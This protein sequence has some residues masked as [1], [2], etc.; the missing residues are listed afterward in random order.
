MLTIKK[1][2]N[3][4][5]NSSSKWFNLWANAKNKHRSMRCFGFWCVD[6]L[7][8][9]M[10]S[11]IIS[12]EYCWK[13]WRWLHCIECGRKSSWFAE[14]KV[15][16]HT[17]WAAQLLATL[18]DEGGKKRN[19]PEAF[20]SEV[21]RNLS[22]ESHASGYFCQHTQQHYTTRHETNLSIYLNA[23]TWNWCRH[24]RNQ[25]SNK[26]RWRRK[27]TKIKTERKKQKE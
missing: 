8:I 27:R 19:I 16:T 6:S 11:A 22:C 12:A 24:I 5:N 3:L 25:N 21:K 2:T 4:S 26:H 15:D 17:R 14:K 23:L 10:S 1:M 7:R 20:W 13:R 9:K 18:S